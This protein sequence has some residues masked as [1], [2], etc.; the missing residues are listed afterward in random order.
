MASTGMEKA[1]MKQL[2]NKA[3]PDSPISFAFGLGKEP[4]FALLMMHKT[5]NPKAVEKE[6]TD[7]SPDAKNTRWGTLVVEPERPNLAKFI[8]NKP[9]SGMAKRLAKTL[10]GTGYPKVEIVLEDGTVVEGASDDEE[11]APVGLESVA[12]GGP[13]VPPPP[14]GPPPVAGPTPEQKAKLTAGLM[15]K[16]KLLIPR[17]GPAGA[18]HP[19]MLEQLKK[20]AND[21][22]ANIKTGNFTY[23]NTAITQLA[24]ALDKLAPGGGAPSGGA[25]PLAESGKLW[26]EAGRQVN[27]EIEKLRAQLVA[28]YQPEGIEKE[29]E[30]SYAKL[31]SPLLDKMKD[32]SLTAK[33]GEFAAATDPAS[34][35]KLVTEATKIVG[36]YAEVL[37]FPFLADL[38]SNPFVAVSIK[39][40]VTAALTG[41]STAIKKEQQGL[42]TA[43]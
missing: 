27:A 10:K 24:A 22:S 41:L 5:K 42:K 7:G 37:K 20:F 39:D 28:A 9:V 18:A 2:L 19:D 16:L 32:A 30:A 8:V 14:P 31:V 11:E 25:A 26:E 4:A 17:I 1:E 40:K 43:A 29:V 15:E 36:G 35:E 33:L 23:A 21:A 38:E 13:G 3:A 12:P 6:L 34:R